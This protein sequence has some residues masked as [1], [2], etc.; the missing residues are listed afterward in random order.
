MSK[1]Q[2]KCI[3]K[4]DEW[5][6]HGLLWM[7]K[8][9]K[10]Q[11]SH[12]KGFV[13]ADR[14]G[15]GKTHQICALLKVAPMTEEPSIV[16]CPSAC[17]LFW[18]DAVRWMTG[19]A[20]YLVVPGCTAAVMP[21]PGDIVI[22]SHSFFKTS[23]SKSFNSASKVAEILDI[24]WGRIVVD[25]A[26]KILRKG[27]MSR[28][29]LDRIQGQIRWGVSGCGAAGQTPG[30]FND[31]TDWTT[32]RVDDVLIRRGIPSM[33]SV[34]TVELEFQSDAERWLYSRAHAI[35]DGSRCSESS[36][37][38]RQLCADVNVFLRAVEMQAAFGTK[39][40]S[41]SKAYSK[42]VREYRES[43]LDKVLTGTKT[44]YIKDMLR[45]ATGDE[46]FVVFCSGRREVAI[47]HDALS[48]AG[49]TATALT[50]QLN[51]ANQAAV[52]DLFDSDVAPKALILTI[53]VGVAG[54]NLQC[55]DHVIVTSPHF[56]EFAELQAVARIER[57]GQRKD[58]KFTR[59][60]VKGTI[61]ERPRC[62][63][64]TR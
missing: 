14:M 9:E 38:C 59:L 6:R 27:S 15:S 2:C 39:V 29:S 21:D 35:H 17:L 51:L 55:A 57:K 54:L 3:Q 40:T 5:Q 49:V 45:Q 11:K 12:V 53:H 58:T 13:I 20:P 44:S 23:A 26:H 7:L 36:L 25:E 1:E 24:K 22:V 52:I 16:I 32:S 34:T 10:S 8:A 50:G 42:L 31:V 41:C 56:S 60:I 18:R 63:H 48:K 43:S 33:T 19:T 28:A 4:L 62:L 37:R 30:Y 47:L 64:S 61:D 46:R